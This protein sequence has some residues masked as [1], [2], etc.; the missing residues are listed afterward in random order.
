[1][2]AK[3][4]IARCQDFCNIISFSIN[5]VKKTLKIWLLAAKASNFNCTK[6]TK[7]LQYNGCLQFLKLQF[8]IF[9]LHYFGE[10]V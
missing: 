8:V 7:R 3:L 10:I 1:M 4:N 2:G 5:M 6:I 9:S